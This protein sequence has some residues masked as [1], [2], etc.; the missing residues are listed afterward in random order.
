MAACIHHPLSSLM[1]GPCSLPSSHRSPS[2]ETSP[3]LGQ[4]LTDLSHSPSIKGLPTP[5]L[6]DRGGTRDR[7][8]PPKAPGVNAWAR[9]S[10]Q[11]GGSGC[12]DCTPLSPKPAPGRTP[13]DH[14]GMRAGPSGW[15][16]SRAL[17]CPR[18][19]VA[20]CPRGWPRVRLGL[21]T[22]D[23]DPGLP[24]PSVQGR[25]PAERGGR[26]SE[27]TD[28]DCR[29][30]GPPWDT[31]CAC[32]ARGR[33]SGSPGARPPRSTVPAHLPP[34]GCVAPWL[35]TSLD[36]GP[37]GQPRTPPGRREWWRRG[38]LGLPSAPKAQSDRGPCGPHADGTCFSGRLRPLVA[39]AG[40]RSRY[41]QRVTILLGAGTL[42][43]AAPT[44]G[45]HLAPPGEGVDRHD[46]APEG[47][48]ME[49]RKGGDPTAPGDVPP[50]TSSP[51]KPALPPSGDPTPCSQL[52]QQEA[53]TSSPH[54][55]LRVQPSKG[56][57]PVLQ[58]DWELPAWQWD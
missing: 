10:Q 28:L 48:Q 7:A 9:G 46:P 58:L 52:L 50:R 6:Q 4:P 25:G 5:S 30:F 24:R 57:R 3:H 21:R 49:P 42:R 11:E 13:S 14:G 23:T 37:L 44:G 29:G 16:C 55:G 18:P 8:E 54:A 32:R 12:Q 17:T 20:A 47:S 19:R 15:E 41:R 39:A 43:T 33:V 26:D 45:R 40:R 38:P 22:R 36:T 1:L 2:M 27:A 56:T 35:R 51:G 31:D 34:T 53:R